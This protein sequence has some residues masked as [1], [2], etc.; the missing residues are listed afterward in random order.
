MAQLKQRYIF[1][2]LLLVGGLLLAASPTG[3]LDA[4]APAGPYAPIAGADSYDKVMSVL[5][6]P[7]CVNCH[8]SDHLP[9]QGLEGRPHHFGV[10]RGAAGHGFEATNC[11]TCHQ[12]ENNDYSG[13][14][15]APHWGLAPASMGWQ[16]LSKAE[17]A[18][19][20]LDRSR[21]G[22][23]SREEL[24]RHLTEDPLVLWAWAP[25]VDVSGQERE[26]PP[27]EKAAYIQ[28]VKDWFAAGT[29]IPGH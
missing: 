28:A 13:V 11:N 3:P 26:Q 14:P 29:P 1:P 9:K 20:L 6:H 16:G 4:S 25:G 23:R 7:R 27:V 2:A 22:G 17:V 5:T 18:E 15:G 21:N 19:A 12:N 24:I 8:P 10:A